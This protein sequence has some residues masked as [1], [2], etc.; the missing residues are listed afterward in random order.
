[1][2]V[3]AIIETSPSH[4]QPSKTIGQPGELAWDHADI[5]RIGFMEKTRDKKP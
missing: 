5:S 1:M 3:T 4:E 2:F